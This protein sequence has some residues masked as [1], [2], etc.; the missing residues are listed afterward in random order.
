[1]LIEAWTA[2]GQ[3]VM[4]KNDT[5]NWDTPMRLCP[6]NESL[7]SSYP[8][9]LPEAEVESNK[10]MFGRGHSKAGKHSA[11][12]MDTLTS[13][14]QCLRCYSIALTK[15][16]DQANSHCWQFQRRSPGVSR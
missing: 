12:G 8:D 14:I 3:F 15:H 6:G 13:L 5:G 10:L 7:V 16:H 9:S 11:C 1:M 4:D 2:R